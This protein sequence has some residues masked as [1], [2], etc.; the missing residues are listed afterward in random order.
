MVSGSNKFPQF[1]LY[2]SLKL[3]KL[4][5]IGKSVF[6]FYFMLLLNQ[7]HYMILFSSFK[8]FTLFHWFK[9]LLEQNWKHSFSIKVI[10]NFNFVLFICPIS[11]ALPVF[12]WSMT[13]LCLGIAL[14]ILVWARI[15]RPLEISGKCFPVL[16]TH[17]YRIKQKWQKKGTYHL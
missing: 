8:L 14:G 17:T 6:L 12:L 2:L 3:S 13:K 15:T 9:V 11:F 10:F 7:H 16:Q 5:A 1:S 4:N